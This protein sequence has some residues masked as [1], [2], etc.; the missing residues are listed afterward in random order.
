MDKL[1]SKNI[2]SSLVVVF[3]MVSGFFVGIMPVSA[4]ISGK[5]LSADVG[6]A[7]LSTIA[8]KWPY[9]LLIGLIIIVF[10]CLVNVFYRTKKKQ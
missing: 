7:D 10:L 1:F 3:S 4:E 8:S 5:E 9:L 6:A 2:F